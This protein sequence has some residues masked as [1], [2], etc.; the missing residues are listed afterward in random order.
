[1]NRKQLLILVGLVVVLGIAGLMLYQR[2][3]TSWQGGGRQGAA[4]K[5]L[6]ELPLNDVA[7][8]VIR[9]GTNELDLLRSRLA[10]F[11]AV[12]RAAE[13]GEYGQ[14]VLARKQVE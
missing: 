14:R 4:S 10:A 13:F 6:G 8:V 1:M 12:V 11:K 3:Q 7:A 2:D 9:S 5:L